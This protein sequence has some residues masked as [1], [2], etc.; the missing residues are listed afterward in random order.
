MLHEAS[1][2]QLP[3][4]ERT[5]YPCLVIICV[6]SLDLQLAIAKPFKPMRS[7][8]RPSQIR[9]LS[10]NGIH[11]SLFPFSV[12]PSCLAFTGIRKISVK[13]ETLPAI[14]NLALSAGHHR[15]QVTQENGQHHVESSGASIYTL[16]YGFLYF[17]ALS[18][19]FS[20]THQRATMDS[21]DS[22]LARLNS[23][24]SSI[25]PAMT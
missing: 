4:S 16:S 9:N 23:R 1:S 8:Q 24:I 3:G 7:R 18:F 10:D 25:L 12:L 13:T 2:N 19:P 20:I 11:R 5:T 6:W 17:F 14:P 21:P 15:R 22:G